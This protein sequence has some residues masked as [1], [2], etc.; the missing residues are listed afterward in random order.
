MTDLADKIEAAGGASRELDAYIAVVMGAWPNTLEAEHS[1]TDEDE[2]S[3]VEREPDGHKVDRFA[4][5]HY[6][7]SLDAAMTLVPEGESYALMTI[8]DVV[9]VGIGDTEGK[10]DFYAVAATPALALCAAALRA[11]KENSDVG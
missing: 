6:T 8:K 5:P 11:H 2:W 9:H 10:A 7:A 3:I 1:V 4:P